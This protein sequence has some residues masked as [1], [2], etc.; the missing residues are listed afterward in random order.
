MRIL[1]LALFTAFLSGCGSGGGAGN[2]VDPG[3]GTATVALSTRAASAA[4][5]IYG[6][7]LVLRLPSGVTLP[8]EA[9][10]EVLP[11]VLRPVDGQT[12]AGAWYVP[13]KDTALAYV[14]VNFASPLGFLVGDLGT[15]TCNVSPGAAVSAAGFML[16][17]ESFSA[18][19]A[20]GAVIAGITP[21]FTVTTK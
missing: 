6:A 2:A 8:A 11:G 19:D 15:M 1:W 20:N 13:A 16:P 21:H 17:P 18:R 5:V 14:K 12:L 4:T 10:G 9:S 7:E 3:P